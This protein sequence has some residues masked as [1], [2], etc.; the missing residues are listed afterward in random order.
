MSLTLNEIENIITQTEGLIANKNFL[1]VLHSDTNLILD[2][3]FKIRLSKCFQRL[4]H[5]Y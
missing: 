2:P 5:V 4:M 3:S 1:K